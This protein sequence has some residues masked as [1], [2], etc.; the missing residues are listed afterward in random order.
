MS[1]A[2]VVC[3]YNPFHAGHAYHLK[4]T[5]AAGAQAVVC[6]MSGHFVQRA[7]PAL[8][9]KWTRAQA[10]VLGG[11][12]L[13]IELP[14]ASAL[15]SAEGFA[16]SAISLLLAA[17]VDCISFGSESGQAAS[18]RKAAQLLCSDAFDPALQQGLNRGL[19]YAA[20]RQQALT[21]LGGDGALLRSPND[22]LAVEYL[23]ALR[24]RGSEAQ[25]IAV[26]RM[27]ASH[28][29][30]EPPADAPVCAA[31]VRRA[32]QTGDHT[33]WDSAIPCNALELYKKELAQT[34]GVWLAPMERA[35]LAQL[36][37]AGMQEL[38]RLPDAADDLC[39]R[40][41]R[42]AATGVTLEQVIAKTCSAHYTKS[43][44]RRVILRHF[45]G[46]AHTDPPA[47]LRVLAFN[48]TGRALLRTLKNGTL[49]LIVKPSEHADLLREE[50]RLTDLYALFASNPLPC[51]LEY[52]TSPRYVVR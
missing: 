31:G 5:R 51:G 23:K 48:D 41:L 19:S 46:L 8:L 45:L 26:T 13:V 10:A 3:E 38:T 14:T 30:T 42:A 27:G 7:E 12:D 9:T 24:R 25:A 40:L 2:G 49:P 44:V 11:A 37:C 22:N 29:Q 20:A 21:M 39:R 50:T 17:G 43:R 32:L 6:V 52:T 15:R 36:R 47:Y 28:H 34:G 16:D 1:I 33:L 35:M 18:L 4:A